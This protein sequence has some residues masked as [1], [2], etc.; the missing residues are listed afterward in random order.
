MS[1][2]PSLAAEDPAAR[3]TAIAEEAMAKHGLRAIIV[4]VVIDGKVIVTLARG[5][6]MTGVPATPD[7]HFR[8]GAVAFA[9]LADDRA[10]AR[11]GEAHRP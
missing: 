1:G 9:Y 11:G 6:S 4:R 8:N 3:I 10:P 7:M 5:E 2:L